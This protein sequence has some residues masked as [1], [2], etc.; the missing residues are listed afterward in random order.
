VRDRWRLLPVIAALAI[1]PP[2]RPRRIN[3]MTSITG[4]CTPM[5]WWPV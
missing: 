2:P 4:S 5:S 1:T 3:A